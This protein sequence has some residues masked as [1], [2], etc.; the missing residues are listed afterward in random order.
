MEE[1]VAGLVCYLG[2]TWEG[3]GVVAMVVGAV[4]G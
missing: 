3:R 4:G 2:L 1:V